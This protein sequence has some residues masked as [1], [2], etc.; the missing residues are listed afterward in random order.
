[1]STT[2]TPIRLA[3]LGCGAVTEIAHLPVA[4]KLPLVQVTLLVDANASRRERLASQYNV[5]HAAED[6]QG[7][8]DTFD[9]AIVA[10]P[11]ALHAVSTIQLLEQGKPVLVEKPLAMT[12]AECDAMIE[13]SE[14]TGAL[15]V[16]GLMRRFLWSLS[17]ARSFVARGLLG[18]IQTIDFREGAIYRW[19][20]ASDFFF[21]K[22]TAGGGV[23]IDTGAHTLDCLLYIAGDFE[24]SEYFDDAEGGVEA[25]CLIKLRNKRGVAGVVELSRTRE[26]RNTGIIR[27]EKGSLEVG[28]GRNYLKLSLADSPFALSGTGTDLRETESK[29]DYLEL[30]TSQL[31]NYVEAIKRKG[32][33][34]A[35]AKSASQSIRMIEACYQNRR[36]LVLPWASADLAGME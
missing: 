34:V 36:P 1:M 23:L 5:M 22:E 20:V 4:S 6:V 18:D 35:D 10:L 15:L 32:E 16:V 24:V 30:I 31:T 26:L 28:L 12:S 9:A 25:N 14:R 19:P 29:Q 27:G 33:P 13:A 11:H 2:Q 17:F 8:Y 7:H 21:K 3:I